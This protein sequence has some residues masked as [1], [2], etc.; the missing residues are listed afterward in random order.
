MRVLALLPCVIALAACGDRRSFDERF[1]DAGTTL[2]QTSTL[3]RNANQLLTSDGKQAIASA[4]Q[5]MKSLEQSSLTIN[6]LLK[7]NQDSV[8]GGLQGLGELGPAIRE[9]RD[10]L[11]S[12]I[13]DAE[14]NWWSP[15]TAPT[16]GGSPAP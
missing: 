10:A 9:L 12:R 13:E 2:E 5:A 7:D 14:A 4:Q 15:P 8:N 6:A 11:R 3:M 16:G 1:N